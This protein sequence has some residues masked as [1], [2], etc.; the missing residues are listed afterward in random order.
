MPMP[1]PTRNWP[2]SIHC[3]ASATALISAP[4][5]RIAMSTRKRRLAAEAVGGGP[6]ERRAERGAENQRRADQADHERAERE[7]R[8]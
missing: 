7:A 3:G 1:T 8:W 6:A 4:A 2:S 5:A